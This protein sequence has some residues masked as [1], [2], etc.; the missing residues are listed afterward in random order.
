MDRH[1]TTAHDKMSQMVRLDTF[2][3]YEALRQQV[4]KHL[5]WMQTGASVAKAMVTKLQPRR[6]KSGKKEATD[7]PGNGSS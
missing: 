6:H 4:Q 7:A 3:G 5:A 1:L 2:A